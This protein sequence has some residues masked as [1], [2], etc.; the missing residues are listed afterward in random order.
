LAYWLTAYQRL[1]RDQLMAHLATHSPDVAAQR[2]IKSL[3]ELRNA[4]L[5]D[6]TYERD[7]R[8][9]HL[10]TVTGTDLVGLRRVIQVGL[11]EYLEERAGRG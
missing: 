2:W 9:A 3:T 7:G 11:T 1:T 4:G 8:K 10:D 6:I 5:V